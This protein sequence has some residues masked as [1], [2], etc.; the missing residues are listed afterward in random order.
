MVVLNSRGAL[1]QIQNS[2]S[3]IKIPN[4]KSKSK[5]S[6]APSSRSTPNDLGTKPKQLEQLR[7]DAEIKPAFD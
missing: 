1:S 5:N 7:G 6:K 3:K 4:Q 2:K